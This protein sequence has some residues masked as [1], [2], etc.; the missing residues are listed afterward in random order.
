MTRR[1]IPMLHIAILALLL[2]LFA[3]VAAFAAEG[4]PST[5]DELVLSGMQLIALAIGAITPLGGYVLNHYAP[6]A[7]EPAKAIVQVVLAAAAGALAQ[8]LKAGNLDVDL[9]TLE[10]VGTAVVAALFTHR[11][12]WL[13]AGIS[14]ALGGGTNRV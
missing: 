3:P 14:T 8:L 6:W 9:E 2:L 1:F 10:V 4:V 13:P 7:S 11:A 5:N 12:L